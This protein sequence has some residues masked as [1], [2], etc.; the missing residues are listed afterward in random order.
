ME[1]F[2]VGEDLRNHLDLVDGFALAVDAVAA[3]IPAG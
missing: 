2:P 1:G 3:I